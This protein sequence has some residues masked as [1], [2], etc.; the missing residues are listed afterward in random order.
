MTAAELL[1][2]DDAGVGARSCLPGLVERSEIADV[3]GEDDPVFSRGKGQLFLIE[4]C[5]FAS[6]FRRQ[7]II[8][9]SAQI[10]GQSG[11]D[12]AVEVQAD[13]KSFKAD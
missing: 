6:F 1:R 12:M 9:A 4:G 3:E 8:I 11:H 13:E 5:I 10:D 2:Y 7:D